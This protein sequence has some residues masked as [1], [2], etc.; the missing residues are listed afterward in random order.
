MQWLAEVCVRRPIFAT[1]LSLVILVI[2]GVFYSKLG[3][4]QFPKIDF[5][6]VTIITRLPGASP[7]DVESEISD[8][9]EGAINTISGID[10]LRSISSEGVSQVVVSFI[11][12]KDVNVAVQE[13]QQK[14]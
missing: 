2:G 9:L 11:L 5:P 14:V 4:D 1:V 13:V 6:A 3:V 12:E 8:K 7:E 10:E